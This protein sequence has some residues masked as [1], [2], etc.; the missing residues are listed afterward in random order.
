MVCT[1][2]AVKSVFA[3]AVEPLEPVVPL[4]PPGS[5]GMVIPPD[6]VGAVVGAVDP[7]QPAIATNAPKDTA[8]TRSDFP[9]I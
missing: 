6:D 7:P 8:P 4:L 2:W 3:A 5:V 1:S 9:L